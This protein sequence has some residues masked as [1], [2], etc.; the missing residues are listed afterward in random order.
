MDR[1]SLQRR[2]VSDDVWMGESR[3]NATTNKY[4]HADGY[5]DT[6]SYSYC[7]G[8]I[9]KYTHADRYRDTNRYSYGYKHIN[10]Y[11]DSYCYGYIYKY[12]HSNGYLYG[13]CH[14]N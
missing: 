6:N 7:Y 3:T 8:H 13:Y 1:D 2:A 14:R 5:R 11:G 9:Y 4:T 12:S 10:P